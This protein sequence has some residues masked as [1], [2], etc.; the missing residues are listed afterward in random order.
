MR[1]V[2]AITLVFMCPCVTSHAMYAAA[3]A[4]LFFLL[5]LHKGADK[6]ALA[7]TT[8]VGEGGRQAGRH[9]ANGRH[10]THMQRTEAEARAAEKSP[11]SGCTFVVHH[12]L[13]NVEEFSATLAGHGSCFRSL[14]HP[15]R[16]PP[17]LCLGQRLS[18]RGQVRQVHRPEPSAQPRPKP[19]HRVEVRRSGRH[20]PSHHTCSAVCLKSGLGLQE[21]LVVAQHV[22]RAS[23][24]L[25]VR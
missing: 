19:L 2:H 14:A 13:A 7:S 18:L 6:K 21:P 25:R 9:V 16:S 3:S 22:P 8:H 11:A 24:P 5:G 1:H 10:F 4:A 17:V 15:L 20:M 12:L 23:F